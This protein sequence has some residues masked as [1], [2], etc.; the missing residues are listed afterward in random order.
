MKKHSGGCHCKAVRYEVETDLE[1]VIEC[2]C[3]HCAIKGLLLTFVP[4]TQFTLLQ[5]EDNL[6]EY[7]FNTHKIQ[8]LFCKTCGV[9]SFGRGT[10]KEGAATIAINARCLDDIDLASLTRTPVDGKSY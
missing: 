7:R 3:S 1:K 4:A 10:N 9:E 6:T 8:H 5:G 2:N